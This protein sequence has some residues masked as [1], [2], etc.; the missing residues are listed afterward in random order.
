MILFWMTQ[1]KKMKGA[2]RIQ[3]YIPAL[4]WSRTRKLQNTLIGIPGLRL[5]TR[6][7]HE[8]EHETAAF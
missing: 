8:Q 6:V 2:D 3:L 1:R 4:A 7:E 5:N